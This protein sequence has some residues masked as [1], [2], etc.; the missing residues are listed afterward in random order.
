MADYNARGGAGSGAPPAK[1]AKVRVHS[2]RLHCAIAIAKQQIL[3]S[4]QAHSSCCVA[5][6]V[7][8]DGGVHSRRSQRRCGRDEE[9]EEEEEGIEQEQE[10]ADAEEAE[11]PTA[12][13]AAEAKE[14]TP[15]ATAAAEKVADEDSAAEE[16]D[17]EE[18]GEEGAY[19][20][21]RWGMFNKAG[22][23]AV[24]KI[25][26]TSTSW[27]QLFHRV[28]QLAKQEKFS[29]MQDTS[30]R[31]GMVE[32]FEQ[33]LREEAEDGGTPLVTYEQWCSLH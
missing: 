3:S 9:E 23:D 20:G 27:H 13:P 8:S 1:K 19:E 14:D 7:H 17:G 18:E 25:M 21:G 10:E 22:D 33:R 32:M 31:E 28:S 2:A 29:E 15:E 4:K 12:Q 6:L 16:E 30:V 5:L 26:E 11:E 24:E